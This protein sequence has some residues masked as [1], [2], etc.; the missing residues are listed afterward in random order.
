MAHWPQQRRR[1][2]EHTTHL[3]FIAPRRWDSLQ[4]LPGTRR[5]RR[6]CRRGRLLLSRGPLQRPGRPARPPLQELNRS[7]ITATLL[8]SHPL[9]AFANIL[10]P[11]PNVKLSPLLNLTLLLNLLSIL[12]SP[13]PAFIIST[14]LQPSLTT[15]PAA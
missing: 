8:P 12:T 9:R 2:K 1:E 10:R 6:G 3:S 4:R 14:S 5:R 7:C 11:S 13:H 15:V